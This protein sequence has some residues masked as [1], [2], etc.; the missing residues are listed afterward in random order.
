MKR[1]SLS[2]RHG[3]R[4]V[5]CRIAR[6]VHAEVKADKQGILNEQLSTGQ[7]SRILGRDTK[8]WRRFAR[9]TFA[10]VQTFANALGTKISILLVG[11]TGLQL[12]PE[13]ESE[14]DLYESRDGSLHV[15]ESSEPWAVATHRA[16]KNFLN[17]Y[18]VSETG[19]V[20]FGGRDGELKHL[21]NWLFNARAASRML[22]AAPSG[23][24]KSA[25]LVNWMESLRHQPQFAEEGWQLAFMPISIHAETN[26]PSIFYGGL[27][28]RLAEIFGERIAPNITLNVEALKQ[29]IQDRLEAASS[30]RR[31]LLVVLDGLD[32]ALQGSFDPSIIP[33]RLPSHVRIVVSARWQVGDV[34][35]TGWLR[36]L[37]WDRRV[38]AEQLTLERLSSEAITDVLLKLGVPTDLLGRQRPIVD[39]LCKLAEGEP[40][41]VRYYAE[42]LWGRGP[43]RARIT[44]S[45][46]ESLKPGFGSYFERWLSDQERLWAEE[47][48][49]IDRRDVDRALSI[50]AFAL[51]PLESRDLLDLV[52]EIHQTS[53][54]LSEHH[55]L[56][57]LRRFVIGNGKAGSGYVLSHPKIAEYLQRQRFSGR[58]V[59]LQKGFVTWGQKLL[60]KLNH[61]ELDP[62]DASPYALQ[63]LHAHFN[64]VGLSARERMELVENG[65]RRAWLNF[66]KGENGFAND[67]LYTWRALQRDGA[68]ANLELQWRCTLVLASIRS[69]GRNVAPELLEQAVAKRVLTIDQAEYI[70]GLM[71]LAPGCYAFARF[72]VQSRSDAIRSD[73]LIGKAMK[74]ALDPQIPVINISNPMEKFARGIDSDRNEPE[75]A[76]IICNL[77]DILLPPAAG[78]RKRQKARIA[79]CIEGSLLAIPDMESKCKIVSRIAPHLPST[80]K[81][82]LLAATLQEA[83]SLE[84][85]GPQ[86]VEMSSD[87]GLVAYIGSSAENSRRCNALTA[88]A[89]HLP[90]RKK[91]TVLAD[92]VLTA[93]SIQDSTLRAE[94]IVQLAPHLSPDLA[95]SLL[96]RASS[97]HNQA[98]AIITALIPRLSGRDLLKAAK[99]TVFI[100]DEEIQIAVLAEFLNRKPFDRERLLKLLV[101]RAKAIA[102][103]EKRAG[104]IAQIALRLPS[105]RGKKLLLESLSI[106]REAKD[107]K[108]LRAGPGNLNKTISGISA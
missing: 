1:G 43:R 29:F 18:L 19:E 76:E 93:L 101:T 70:A 12:P 71:V 21:D 59:V 10:N 68:L 31:R 77:L 72:A 46:L 47:K 42:D 44:I 22:V 13:V 33:P 62:Q 88:L 86:L 50:L 37:G 73:S 28:Q 40:I 102:N 11:G 81:N 20:P 107:K 41:L 38:R 6:S 36:K 96:P 82:K 48:Q 83:L 75:R 8:P 32:E 39:R 90:S 54:F 26:R 55:L 30:G 100:R 92:A 104:A 49:T 85:R 108:F 4:W 57:P 61:D 74:L 84:Y 53:D 60:R 24:G 15:I 94:V 58:S 80:Q 106:A 91:K 67:V 27:A 9:I 16:T 103:L 7:Q 87:A 51:G 34:D 35:S 69:L 98:A 105:P 63:F 66:E 2:L 5:D 97:F 52:T 25:L 99:A 17:E 23:R 64:N 45:D 14:E 65:W 95:S 3:E 79:S 56:Q 78:L 89:P